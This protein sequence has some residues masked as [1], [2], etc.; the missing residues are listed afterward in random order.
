[1]DSDNLSLRDHLFVSYAWEDLPL[2]EWLTFKLTAEGYKVWCDRVKLF[3]GESFP[4]EI[5]DAI[6]NRTHRLLAILSSHSLNKP[7]PLKERNLALSIS[8]ERKI[9]FLVP[10]NLGLKPSELPWMIS[11]LTFVD[12]SANWASGLSQLLKVLVK[13]DTPCPLSDGKLRVVNSVIPP[14]LMLDCSERIFSNIYSVLRVPEIIQTFS[15]DRKLDDKEWETL[16]QKWPSYRADPRTYLSFM[17]PPL[18]IGDQFGLK[19]RAK[20]AWRYKDNVEGIKSTNIVS[21]LIRNS[22][23]VRFI[24]K[25]LAFNKERK[26]LHFS[27]DLLR[28]NRLEFDGPKEK[29]TW[30]SVAGDRTHFT[31][32]KPKGKFQYHLSPDISVRQDLGEAFTVCLN[33]RVHIGDS[34]GDTMP[35]LPSRSRRARVTHD[36]WNWEWL[37]RHLGISQFLGDEKKEIVIGELPNELLIISANPIIYTSPKGLNEEEIEKRRNKRKE[38]VLDGSDTHGTTSAI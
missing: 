37:N 6:K 14:E 10:L 15:S 27:K 36:W 25:G 9:D 35:D 11:D 18:D 1:M 19:V 5:D 32:G 3:G 22:L 33:V 20:A 23:I 26:W 31:P 28:G 2:A 38:A 4:K 7:N 21:N 12:F 29:R 24:E 8:S 34:T 13:A 16:R 17:S 30:I